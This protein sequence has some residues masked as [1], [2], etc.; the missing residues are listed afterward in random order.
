LKEFEEKPLAQFTPM[1]EQLPTK[2]S[3]N[4]DPQK[5]AKDEKPKS[6]KPPFQKEF[7]PK[8]EGEKKPDDKKPEIP[9]KPSLVD[10]MGN[11]KPEEQLECDECGNDDPTL[12]DR[13]N[14]TNRAI[15]QSLLSIE[16]NHNK[17]SI[18]EVGS[19]YERDLDVV[20]GAYTLVSKKY[21]I[22][23]KPDPLTGAQF[24]VDDSKTEIVE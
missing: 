21:K 1:K 7:P 10:A 8:K 9:G 22:M 2:E 23:Q 19:M 3:P 12:F 17:Q 16:A 5:G 14:P 4:I 11:S 13:P 20:D 6:D 18:L 24:Q 15:V